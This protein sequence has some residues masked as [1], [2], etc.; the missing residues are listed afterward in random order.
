MATPTDIKVRPLT[1]ALLVL[2]VLFVIVAIVYFT[3]TADGLPSFLPGHQAGLTK[4]H[5]K[6]GIA[7]LGLA[8]LSWVGAWFSTASPS[9]ST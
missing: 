2:G 1:I 3:K 5:T 4:H 8:V 7:M 9:P 6:H